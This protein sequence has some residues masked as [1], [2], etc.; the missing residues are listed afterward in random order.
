[1]S[2]EKTRAE[3]VRNVRSVLR[4]G[5]AVLDY[6]VATTKMGTGVDDEIF[7]RLRRRR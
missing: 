1:V 4:Q 7:G 5:A 3:R 2:T 6:A